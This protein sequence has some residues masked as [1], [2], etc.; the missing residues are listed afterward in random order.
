MYEDF[1]GNLWIGY[2]GEGLSRIDLLQKPFK[3]FRMDPADPTS[4]NDNTVFCFHESG[5]EML[6][7]TYTVVDFGAAICFVVGSIMFFSEAWLIPGTWLFL[8]GS[9]LFACKPSIRLWR[10]LRLFATGDIDTLAERGDDN[11]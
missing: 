11:G 4:I 8:L 10:E 1:S 2:G 3:T 7:G 9:M 6:V 5:Q